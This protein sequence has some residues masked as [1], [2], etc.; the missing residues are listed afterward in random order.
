MK[1]ILIRSGK[2]PLR[3]ATPTEFIHQDLIG[4]NTGNLLFGDSA[5][6]MLSAPDTEVVSNGIRTDPSARRAAEINERYDAFVVPLANAFRPA[7][8]ASLDRLSTLVEQL[9]VVVFGVGART[10]ADYDTEPLRPMEASVKRFVSAVLERSA[11][12][13]VRDGSDDGHMRYRISRL[14]ERTAVANARID[15][16]A[17]ETGELRARLAAAEERAD[18]TGRRLA[19]AQKELAAAHKRLAALERRVGGIEKRAMV[20]IGPP[21]AAG[22]AA[23]PGAA[24]RTDRERTDRD[25][26]DRDGT[27]GAPSKITRLSQFPYEWSSDDRS[28]RRR[29]YIS[30]TV[31]RIP[32]RLRRKSA[33][34]DIP[35]R[36]PFRSR[37]LRRRARPARHRLRRLRRG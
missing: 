23:S 13:P 20:R 4:T 35:R 6:K 16:R 31:P 1:R 19:A 32:P 28:R 3:V 12:M 15:K 37:R 7:F 29:A 33:P 36:P 5:H 8:R 21:S 24:G 22:R 17:R 18:E 34:R 26:T 10:G 30:G 27:P 9:T 14:R 25:R 2:S 11:S